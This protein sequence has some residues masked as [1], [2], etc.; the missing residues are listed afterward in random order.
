M[1]VLARG[2]YK[3]D[4]NIQIVRAEP[5]KTGQYLRLGTAITSLVIPICMAVVVRFAQTAKPD[6]RKV[7]Q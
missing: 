3:I 6:R 5:I 2:L 1:K 7:Y 4:R